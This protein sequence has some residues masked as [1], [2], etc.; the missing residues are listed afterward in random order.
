MTPNIIAEPELGA[1]I[2]SKVR[3][4]PKL[5]TNHPL[6]RQNLWAQ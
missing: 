1:N 5:E 4:A 2:H 3:T 6:D